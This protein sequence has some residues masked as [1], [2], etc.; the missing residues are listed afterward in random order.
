MKPALTATILTLLSSVILAEI[1]PDI[2]P[3]VKELTLN[4]EIV[5]TSNFGSF[6]VDEEI[7]SSLNSKESNLR[8][9]DSD[10]TEVPFLLRTKK[11]ERAITRERPIPFKKLSFKKLPDNRIEIELCKESDNRY[12]NTKLSSVELSSNIKNF[13]KH[14]SIWSS[15]NRS[16]W[17]QI[18]KDK[19]IFDYSKFINIR[20][21]HVSFSS[22]P[23][24]Y[25]KIRI[26]NISEK[27]QSP[28]TRLSRTMQKGAELSSVESSSF[29]R[30]DF[31]INE[32]TFY[33]KTTDI[34]K[35]KILKQ[36][37]TSSEFS[38]NE[39]DENSLINFVTRKAPITKITLLT[40]T[41][42][43]YRHLTLQTSS[44]G[45]TWRTAHTG[46][47]SSVNTDNESKKDQSI[48]LQRPIRSANYRIS[49]RNNDSPPLAITDIELEGETREV[50]FYC[51][52]AKS[53][54]AIYGA[55][56]ASTPI[57]DIAEVLT[58]TASE[59]TAQ[60]S[61]APQAENPG[62]SVIRKHKSLL[63]HRTIMTIAVILMI[64]ALGWL[65]AQTVKN[66][67]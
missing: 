14:V 11:G 60:Y 12:N 6:E 18:A 63:S 34:V 29:T 8:I 45:K 17:K 13:E 61:A 31:K 37:Y 38:M 47:I 49:I 10:D 48:H 58:R 32:I 39:L 42:F 9:I 21:S 16:D 4:K 62:F 28:F 43:F 15:E 44:D 51:D 2:H 33:E 35:G 46:V 36:P 65:I 25:F 40:T 64:A 23:A 22:S 24:R 1:K 3:F 53:Y 50:V 59:N 27:Q 52:T 54:R 20:N 5:N 30:T 57:Y 56:E 55:E 67:E 7:F 19:A 26:S 41:P 66:I